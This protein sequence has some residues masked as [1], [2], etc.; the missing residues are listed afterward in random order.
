M[1]LVKVLTLMLATFP[2][3]MKILTFHRRERIEESD[4]EITSDG[5]KEDYVSP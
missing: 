4:K 1:E 3:E 5:K 2:N